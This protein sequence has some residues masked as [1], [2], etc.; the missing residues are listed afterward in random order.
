MPKPENIEKHKFKKGQS[1]NPK[2]RPKLP[3]LKDALANVLGDE[4]AQKTALEAMLLAV[5]NRAIRTGDTRA[6]E[7]LLKYAYPKATQESNVP[8]S[9]IT[10][11]WGNNAGKD[12]PE[13]GTAGSAEEPAEV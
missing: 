5:R 11:V 8:S 9:D 13:Q 6:V 2:G 3:N 10:I 7:L 1:G 12:K 4:Q